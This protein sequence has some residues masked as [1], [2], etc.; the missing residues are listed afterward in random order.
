MAVVPTINEYSLIH[1]KQKKENTP[2]RVQDRL[3]VVIKFGTKQ[4][5]TIKK[6]NFWE[7]ILAT[8]NRGPAAKTTILDFI[9]K[10][11]TSNPHK[12]AIDEKVRF[13]FSKELQHSDIAI[14]LAS[15]SECHNRSL[16]NEIVKIPEIKAS[17]NSKIKDGDTALMLAIRNNNREAFDALIH[18]DGISLNTPNTT[19][20]YTALV[21]AIELDRVEFA[22]KLLATG[23]EIPIKA[24]SL[25]KNKT[26]LLAAIKTASAEQKSSLLVDAVE[27]ANT[28][29]FKK[30]LDE[31]RGLD[32]L[33]ALEQAIHNS[34]GEMVQILLEHGLDKATALEAALKQWARGE[35]SE[36]SEI[37]KKL[38]QNSRSTLALAL[39]NLAELHPGESVRT[40]DNYLKL[41]QLFIASDENLLANSPGSYKA[42]TRAS[43]RGNWNLVA[44]LITA[45]ANP[46]F[47]PNG[48]S[49]LLM[50]ASSRA[51]PE[52]VKLLLE[53]GAKTTYQDARN[54]TAIKRAE[55]RLQHGHIPGG[56]EEAEEVLDLLKE[57]PM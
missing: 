33:P 28:N 31:V 10:A 49:K 35:I 40:S 34:S 5:L 39:L 18:A 57:Q 37:L 42:L 51:G 21:L 23:C 15:I 22:K 16:I 14:V 44:A 20:D 25:S 6:L 47:E 24:F 53:H 8:C 43:E 52:V 7:R 4:S 29:A 17:I 32:T 41:M 46:N 45:G 3:V 36:E 12:Q 2:K 38:V 19:N 54:S 11:T 9:E 26:P 13:I 55:R 50:R 56:K 48:A 30:I 1:Y 27:H